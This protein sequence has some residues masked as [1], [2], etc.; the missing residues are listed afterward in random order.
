M[1]AYRAES[2]LF[3]FMGLK[4]CPEVLPKE[5][6]IKRPPSDPISTQHNSLSGPGSDRRVFSPGTCSSEQ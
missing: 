4:R 2:R 3:I 5:R 6:S 1:T